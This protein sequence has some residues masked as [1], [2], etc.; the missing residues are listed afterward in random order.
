[1]ENEKKYFVSG[2]VVIHFEGDYFADNEDEAFRKALKELDPLGELDP[3]WYDVEN[4]VVE[5]YD[6]PDTINPWDFF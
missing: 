2:D 1:M 6:P 3:F 5:E 4:D